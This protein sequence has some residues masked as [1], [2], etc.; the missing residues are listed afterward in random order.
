MHEQQH[1]QQQQHHHQTTIVTKE[2]TWQS[3]TDGLVAGVEYIDQSAQY[4]AEA[5]V[6]LDRLKTLCAQMV[7][8]T[9]EFRRCINEAR[10]CHARQIERMQR[11]R[12]AA[13]LAA[14]VHSEDDPNSINQLPQE[15]DLAG[16]KKVRTLFNIF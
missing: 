15:V 3:L 10:D 13:L 9:N 7:K 5:N 1:Q 4:I 12:D 14:R 11:E 16:V 8:A 2:E 6:P